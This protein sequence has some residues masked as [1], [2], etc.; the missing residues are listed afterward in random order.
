M[1]IEP[2]E[3]GGETAVLRAG[4]RL[5]AVPRSHRRLLS[6]P[7]RAVF[8]DVPSHFTE[9]A[10]RCPFPNMGR[11]L[12]SLVESGRWE[13]QLVRGPDGADIRAGFHWTSDRVRGATVTLPVEHTYELPA[14][15]RKY[16]AL[17]NEVDWMGWPAA[18]G[19]WGVGAWVS[20]GAFAFDFRGDPIDPR[21]T[22]QLGGSLC[23]DMLVF[24]LDD[25]AGWLR[26]G[27]HEVRMIGSIADAIDWVFGELLA[28][29]V[30]EMGGG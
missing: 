10:A 19:L 22:F 25:R 2:N 27:S 30:P 7:V 24:T 17:V 5:A 23:G 26:L 8:G 29:R 9:I 14:T 3:A 20:P 16:H 6:A 11:W 28:R 21:R 18:G 15:L 12:R 13:L 4:D 1:D